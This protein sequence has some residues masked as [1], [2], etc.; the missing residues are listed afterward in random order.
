MVVRTRSIISGSCMDCKKRA[1]SLNSPLAAA[2]GGVAVPKA[3]AAAA[4]GFRLIMGCCC[5][6]GCSFLFL[7][8][9]NHCSESQTIRENT[10][11]KERVNIQ[12]LRVRIEC[13]MLFSNKT[14]TTT[15]RYE[16]SCRFK[17]IQIRIHLNDDSVCVTI[18]CTR[19]AI[20]RSKIHPLPFNL[21]DSTIII[22][23]IPTWWI[24]S[25]KA[26]RMAVLK[27]LWE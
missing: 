15:A 18:P 11:R 16:W 20:P 1:A 24:R 19:V 12:G 25:W 26:S 13:S 22:I 9:S 17:C 2:C 23:K 5:C 27:G 6:C 7:L 8:E 4:F 3:G 21:C 14:T 10:K